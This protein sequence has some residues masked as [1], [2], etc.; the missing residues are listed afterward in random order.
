VVKIYFLCVLLCLI[1]DFLYN[2][3]PVA[4]NYGFD[5]KIIS[6]SLEEHYS[7]DNEN[8]CKMLKIF[9]VFAYQ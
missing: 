9:V 6:I 2:M 4:D 5:Y 1:I 8:K 7:F 3:Q